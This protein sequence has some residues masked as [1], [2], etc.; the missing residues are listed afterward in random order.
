MGDGRYDYS[1]RR[2]LGGGVLLTLSHPFD[3]LRW[4]V[5][6]IVR[7]RVAQGDLSGPEVNIEATAQVTVEFDNGALGSIDLNYIEHPPCHTLRLVGRKGV[8]VWDQKDDRAILCARGNTYKAASAPAGFT[9]NDLILDE[10]RHFIACLE[11][12][13]TSHCGMQDG[14]R[15]LEIALAARRS[16][17]EGRS[18]DV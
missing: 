1:T 7:V 6:E 10:M 17:E 13:E 4:I 15:A 18:I 14:V 9:R 5:G 12:R 2:D 3:Y 16:A 11:R 8:I